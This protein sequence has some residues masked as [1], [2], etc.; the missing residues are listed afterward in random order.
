MA[1]V[2][3]KGDV[4]EAEGFGD[5]FVGPVEVFGGPEEPEEP[6]DGVSDGS[7]VASVIEV[8]DVGQMFEKCDV[9][10]VGPRGGRVFSFHAF[11]EICEKGMFGCPPRT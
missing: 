1:A 9:G 10:G 11:K 6:Q 2:D 8:K 7:S 3:G 4:L 5:G